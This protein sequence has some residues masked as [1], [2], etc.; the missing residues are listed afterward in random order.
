[1]RYNA[2]L[3]RF[4]EVFLKRGKRPFFVARLKQEL[5]RQIRKVGPYRVRERHAMLLVVHESSTG[6]TLLDIECGAD[7]LGAISRIFGIAS[8]SPCRLTG[9]EISNLEKEVAAIAESD[10]GSAKS[11]KIE[12]SRADKEFPLDSM[13]LNRRLGAVVCE[14]AKGIRVQLHAPE[15]TLHCLITKHHAALFFDV[16]KGPGGLPVGSTGKV[17]LLLSGGIDSPVAGWLTMRRGCNLDAVHF[18]AAPYTPPQARNKV[19]VLASLLARYEPE[20]NLYIVPFGG[21]QADIR[22]KVPGKLLVVLYRR[23]MLRIAEQIAQKEGAKALVT[24]ENL[25]QVASQTLENL[26][27]IGAVTNMPVIRPLITYDKV[28]IIELAKRIGSYETSILPYEDC[29]SLFVPPHP[30]TAARLDQVE[31]VEKRLDIEA[32][33][34]SATAAAEHVIIRS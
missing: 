7:L 16:I 1:M 33:V 26:H 25:G 12:S 8:F 24:G 32:M 9:R 15:F 28:E 3:V 11:F 22:E 30:E 29:C 6:R 4:S 20:L 27:A 13:E 10:L 21:I 19:E 17:M 18:E 23:M 34:A 31:Y 14:R 2:V 5:E